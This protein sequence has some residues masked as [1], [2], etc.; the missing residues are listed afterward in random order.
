MRWSVRVEHPIHVRVVPD[1]LWGEVDYESHYER[2][3]GEVVPELA[4][5]TAAPGDRRVLLNPGPATTTDS[6]K[7]ALVMTDVCPRETEFCDRMADVRHRLAAVSGDPTDVTAIPVVGS[8]TTALEATLVSFV[9]DDGE[10]VVVENGDYG[11]RLLDI[12]K[13]YGIR[14][15]AYSPGWGAPVDETALAE[16]L[17][18]RRGSATHLFFIHH[19]TSSGLLNP[20]APMVRLARE[21]GLTTMVD[22]MSSYG[23]LD[24]PVGGAEGA[25]VVV[26]SANKCIQGMA[27][28]LS[29]SPGAT[30]SMRRAA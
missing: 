6:V 5:R 18:T 9:P 13:T 4:R 1:L 17:E 21:H 28:W 26:S 15:T 20:I 19:E 11:T 8:G 10:V 27:A 29:P 25:D 23:V 2:L 16:V 7:H 12:A 24:V 22:A 3:V 30:S 14:H